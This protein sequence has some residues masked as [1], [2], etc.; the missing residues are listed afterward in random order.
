MRRLFR[1]M[2]TNRNAKIFWYFHFLY[3]VITIFAVATVIAQYLPLPSKYEGSIN[4]AVWIITV[5]FLAEYTARI[6][7]SEHKM[8]YI[9]SFWGLLDLISILPA[10]VGLRNFSVLKS[11]RLLDIFNASRLLHSEKLEE[12]YEETKKKS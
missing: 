1:T 6:Y 9:L 12:V 4:T 11:A 8:N 5:I 2:F 10:I 3:L 7:A